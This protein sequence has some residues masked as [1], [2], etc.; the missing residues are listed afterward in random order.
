MTEHKYTNKLIQEKSPYLLQHA[1]NPVDW[2]P[3]G[4]EAFSRAVSED[5]PIFLSIGYSTCHWCHVMERESFEDEEVAKMLNQHFITI[6]VDREERPDIDHIYMSVCQALTGQ[7]GWPLTIFMSPDKTPFYAGTYFP[8]RDRMGMSGLISLLNSIA[9]AWKDKRET[10][11]DSGARIIE[12]VTEREKRDTATLAEEDFHDAFSQFK[13][14]F[15]NEYGGFGREPK[16][17]TPHNLYFLLRYWYKTGEKAA[18][19]MVEKTLD[20]MRRGGIY[21]HIG[22]GFSR[23]STDKRWLV[24]HFEKMLYDNALL[25]IAYLETYQ[26]T[27]KRNYAQTAEQVFSYVL[28]DMTSPEGCFYSAED[29][30]SEGEEGKFYVWKKNEIVEVLGEEAAKAYCGYFDITDVGNFEGK[31]IPNLIRTDIPEETEEFIVSCREKLFRYREKRVHPY[32]DDKI[33]TA[34]NGLMVAAL[35]IGGRVLK[36]S[37]YSEAA[38]KAVRFIYQRLIRQ[39]GRLLAR[40]RDGDAGIP[41]YVDDYAF[42]S[43]GLTELYETTFNPDYLQKAVKLNSEMLRLFWDDKEGG[44]FIY[45]TD[46]EQLIMR[47]K[48]IYDGATPSGNSVAALNLL[49]LARLTGD[50][51]LE[52]KGNLLLKAFSSSIKAY[53]RAYSFSLIAL[54]FGLTPSQE[55]VIVADKNNEDAQRMLDIVREGFRPFTVIMLYSEEKGKVKEV[56]PFIADYGTVKGRTA[57]YVCQD[58]TCKAPVTD[59]EALKEL[60]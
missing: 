37:E 30:D 18:L 51:S 47:P 54:L 6:K 10:I 43:W 57:A 25:A 33:L 46:G 2:Y 38:E 24:P 29:A 36:N 31:N 4:P 48:E 1:N 39:D 27:G 34:W 5:K 55:I 8:K 21:D 26:I 59:V 35:A 15:D 60:L 44:L 23:Y 11:V 19:E 32:K 53:P 28:R 50:A 52:E 20:A 17:P 58:F 13:A 42:L 56:A 3:W 12:A 14:D 40:Y 7:G 22:Y 16:F 41:A 49:K 9:A 45:G